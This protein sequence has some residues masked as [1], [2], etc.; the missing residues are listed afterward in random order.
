MLDSKQDLWTRELSLENRNCFR[1]GYPRNKLD[2]LEF[3][4]WYFLLRVLV[5]NFFS[6]PNSILLGILIFSCLESGVDKS[7]VVVLAI[8]LVSIVYLFFK[9]R[10]KEFKNRK[11]AIQELNKQKVEVW[12]SFQFFEK[13]CE[14]VFQWDLVRIKQGEVVPADVVILA[15]VSGPSCLVD[16]S[17]LF[18]TR[19]LKLKKPLKET[20]SL[21]GSSGDLENAVSKL[22]GV[23]KVPSASKKF[24]DFKAEF[25]M[26]DSPV[27]SKVGLENFM[28]RGS[29]LKQSTVLGLAV[30]VGRETKLSQNTLFL[31]FRVTYF[32]TFFRNYI[33]IMIGIWGSLLL[34]SFLAMDSEDFW[35]DFVTSAVSLSYLVP[36]SVI[37]YIEIIR[38]L[39]NKKVQKKEGETLIRKSDALETSGGTGY[40][41]IEKSA[42]LKSKKLLP[43]EVYFKNGSLFSEL[44][45]TGDN[46]LLLVA[47][48]VCNTLAHNPNNSVPVKAE[49]K[50]LIK[51]SK[52]LGLS[53][54]VIDETSFRV[55]IEGQTHKFKV[56]SQQE[57]F[58]QKDRIVLKN[59]ETKEVVF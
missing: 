16:E 23:L 45:F 35:D 44:E 6:Q 39:F 33:L 4:Y 41:F 29:V 17:P 28:L 51:I 15:K 48:R 59:L 21:V 7:N 25:K 31:N 47:L 10:I 52:N 56:I 46:R 5:Q 11:K 50:A 2:L 19:N 42:L 54:E 24:T 18:G 32:D 58:D 57:F 37:V 49:D 43:K 36:S 30:Y 1:H 38:N 9:K 40:F 20:Q 26:P 34:G 3:S 22:K 14:E 53:L 8:P 13:S 55:Y 27:S 12:K